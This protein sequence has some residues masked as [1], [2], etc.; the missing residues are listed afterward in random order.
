[1]FE[2]LL[3]FALAVALVRAGRARHAWSLGLGSA[4]VYLVL[5]D[6]LAAFAGNPGPQQV[7]ALFNYFFLGPGSASVRAPAVLPLPAL[8]VAQPL[9]LRGLRCALSGVAAW[10]CFGEA[11]ELNPLVPRARALDGIALSFAGAAVVDAA[12]AVVLIFALLLLRNS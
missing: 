4:V 2:L 12:E 3:C 10:R 11:S 9:L 8:L 5:A 7:F 1:M 6:T